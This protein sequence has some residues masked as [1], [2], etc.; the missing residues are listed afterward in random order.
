[1]HAAP[2]M[3]CLVMLCAYLAFLHASITSARYAIGQTLG[4][5]CTPQQRTLLAGPVRARIV[6]TVMW[7]FAMSGDGDD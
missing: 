2:G 1:M 7:D 3:A 5:Y 6:N 4:I